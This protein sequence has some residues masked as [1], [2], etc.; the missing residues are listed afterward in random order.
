MENIL[1]NKEMGN[2]CFEID[3]EHKVKMKAVLKV[4][5]SLN[6]RCFVCDAHIYDKP[7]D[8]SHRIMKRTFTCSKECTVIATEELKN[9]P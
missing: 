8:C 4:I 9:V 6:M 2:E 5:K 7:I 1:S 3:G